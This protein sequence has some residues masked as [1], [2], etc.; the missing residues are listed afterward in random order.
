MAK[1]AQEPPVPVLAEREV[2]ERDPE[3]EEIDLP[4]PGVPAVVNQPAIGLTPSEIVAAIQ[5]PVSQ[6]SSMLGSQ[7][8]SGMDTPLP[9]QLSSVPMSRRSSGVQSFQRT[10][11]RARSVDDDQRGQKRPAEGEID[12]QDPFSGHGGVPEGPTDSA[13]LEAQPAF[14]ALTMTW[15]QLCNVAEFR[16]NLHPLLRLQSAVE[17][18]RRAPL[19]LC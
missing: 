9:R 13:P 18:D 3:P 15:E 2:E 14:D 1:E 8:G 17:L 7:A 19:D 6:P 10:L 16:E 4:V 11:D 5:P 12:R